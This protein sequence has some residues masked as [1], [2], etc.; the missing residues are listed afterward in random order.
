MVMNMWWVVGTAFGMPGADAQWEPLSEGPPRVECVTVGAEPWCR[1]TGLVELPIDQVAA[2]LEDM[3]AHQALFSSIVSIKVVAPDT[4]HIVLDF[5]GFMGMSDRDYV[6]KYTR[7]TEG[8]ARLYRWTSVQHADA[9]PIEGII[10]LPKM[11]GEWRLVPE[12]A[13]T[14]VTYTWQAE[15]A[16]SFPT[17]LLSQARVK[18]GG[19][20]LKDI[21]KASAAAAKGG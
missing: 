14:R 16:G 12:G 5:P 3:P 17:R 2:T 11:A 19:E 21:E 13:N 6:A 1:S 20:A 18:A 10:R 9:P 15:I 7:S 4:M 8:D